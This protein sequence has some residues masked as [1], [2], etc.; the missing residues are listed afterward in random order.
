MAIHCMN[1]NTIGSEAEALFNLTNG[2]GKNLASEFETTII[3]LKAHWIGSDAKANITDLINV[4]TGLVGLLKTVQTLIV[5]VNNNQ[6]LPL[7]RE[8]VASGGTCTIGSELAVSLNVTETISVPEDTLESRADNAIVTD[9]S[10]FDGFPTKF[11]TFITSLNDCKDT[12]LNNWTDG[13]NRQSVVSAFSTFNENVETYSTNL[14]KVKDNINTV[15]S[16]K[17][18]LF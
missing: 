2:D 8:I 1:P 9:A 10:T 12:L 11:T 4:Y 5:D 18:K 7:Q 17:Q 3:N 13:A 14:T 15:A 6:I 16:N